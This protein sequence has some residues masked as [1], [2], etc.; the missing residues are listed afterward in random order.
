MAC[1]VLRAALGTTYRGVTEVS[2]PPVATL[3]FDYGVL[4]AGTHAL[5]VN[6]PDLARG[7][8][9]PSASRPTPVPLGALRR[10]SEPS[11]RCRECTPATGPTVRRAGF[12]GRVRTGRA[13]VLVHRPAKRRRGRPTTNDR[14]RTGL[15][16]MG[17]PVRSHRA[18]RIPVAP[19]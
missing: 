2:P 4:A 5:E 14:A 16:G 1:L 13:P 7:T 9:P 18:Y 11:P 10:W 17:N 6:A 8:Y 15:L 12:R 19:T 3:D